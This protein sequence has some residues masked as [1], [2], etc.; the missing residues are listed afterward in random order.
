[1]QTAKCLQMGI[2]QGEDRDRC[3][4]IPVYFLGTENRQNG[5][6]SS[7]NEET[8]V[9]RQLGY[10][11]VEDLKQQENV[12]HSFSS[13]SSVLE[14]SIGKNSAVSN[15]DEVESRA[16]PEPDLILRG[17]QMEVAK[18]GLNGEKIIICLPTGSGKTKVAV[19]STKDHLDKSS[20]R[21]WKICST[22][23]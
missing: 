22:C 16:S 15:E 17:Y 1:M 11:I 7:T 21:A 6:K 8:E 13:E 23:Y 14:T 12:N 5:M 2:F 10:A 4:G 18:P 20:I 19:Y 9:T 3:Y